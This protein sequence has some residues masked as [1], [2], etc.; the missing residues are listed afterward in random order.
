[1][2]W[3]HLA[4]LASACVFAPV[5]RGYIR[6]YTSPGVYISRPDFANVQLLLNE[7]ARVPGLLNSDG[8]NN[9]HS[10]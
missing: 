7:R 5:A 6:V 2:S 3:P 1:M 9:D 4:V 8:K 10:R